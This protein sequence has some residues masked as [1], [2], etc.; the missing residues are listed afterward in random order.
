MNIL[1]INGSPRGKNGLSSLLHSHII[2]GFENAGANVEV[3]YLCEKM[4]KKCSGCLSC[5]II[6]PGKCIA[7]ILVR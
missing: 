6:T 2:K 4:I 5:L 3:I 1:F 7:T